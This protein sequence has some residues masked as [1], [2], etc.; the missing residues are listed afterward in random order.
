MYGEGHKWNWKLVSQF[1]VDDFFY[2]SGGIV[3]VEDTSFEQFIEQETNISGYIFVW[4]GHL[5][6]GFV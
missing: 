6:P 2:K 5:S 4:K 1:F 3:R